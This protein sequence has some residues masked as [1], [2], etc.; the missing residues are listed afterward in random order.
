MGRSGQEKYLDSYEIKN[1][2]FILNIAFLED[3]LAWLNMLASY[4]LEYRWEW[5][6]DFTRLSARS[7]VIALT[8]PL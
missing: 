7:P 8:Y 1:F 4:Y 5:V 3:L 2:I 6:S